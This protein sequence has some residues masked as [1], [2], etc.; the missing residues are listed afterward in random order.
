MIVAAGFSLFFLSVVT[1]GCQSIQVKNDKLANARTRLLA[2]PADK[3][4]LSEIVNLLRYDTSSIARANAA[5]ALGTVAE[6]NAVAIKDA[7]VPA[8]VYALDHDAIGVRDAAARALVKFGPLAS[9]A[10]PVLR[11]NLL[12][13]NTSVAWFSAEALGSI[14]EPAREAVPDLVKV[15]KDNAESCV[16]DHANICEYAAVALGKIRPAAH[17][18]MPDLVALLNHEDPYF[19][20]HLA[21]G[22]VRID[23]QNREAFSALE[24]LLKDKDER[25]RR[26]TI[27][28]LSDGDWEASPVRSLIQAALSDPD[29]SVRSAAAGI[30]EEKKAHEYGYVFEES[31]RPNQYIM[32]DGRKNPI[33]FDE[34]STRIAVKSLA[35]LKPGILYQN[36]QGDRIFVAGEYDNQS[37]SFRLSHWY[38][39]VPFQE[40]L[41]KD[42]T[43]VPHKFHSRRRDSLKRTDF[44]SKN[45]FDPNDPAFDPKSFQ[46]GTQ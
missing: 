45:G 14:G 7:A 36:S 9:P 31:T 32:I 35:A 23:P 25:V 1:F 20:A 4:A 6:K 30:L 22:M 40:V 21:A 16:G 33:E 44:E 2:N 26:V 3:A 18:V 12:P 39:K 24:K 28:A 5:A 34:A 38:I 41:T 10:V 15:I 27:W 29:E 11:K 8:L 13:A 46:K 19:R 43:Q 42:E 37:H 17:D